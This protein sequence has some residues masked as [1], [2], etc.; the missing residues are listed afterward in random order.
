M[1]TWR[2]GRIISG[3]LTDGQPPNTAPRNFWTIKHHTQTDEASGHDI[4]EARTLLEKK[5]VSGCI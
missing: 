4:V 2:V 3:T 1:E 5:L